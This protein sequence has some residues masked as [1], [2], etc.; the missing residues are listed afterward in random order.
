MLPKKGALNA[1]DSRVLHL[2]EVINLML[3][4]APIEFVREDVMKEAVLHGK[5]QRLHASKGSNK[6][7]GPEL[8]LKI[9]PQSEIMLAQDLQ[10]E[11]IRFGYR[12]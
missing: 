10:I 11:A 5:P 1:E 12:L 8:D 7:H 6:S 3:A 4:R 2:Q 9:A